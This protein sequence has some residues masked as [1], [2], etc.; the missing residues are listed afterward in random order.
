MANLVNFVVSVDVIDQF[1]QH[2]AGCLS[3]SKDSH[4]F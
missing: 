2:V 4:P 3:I 1:W